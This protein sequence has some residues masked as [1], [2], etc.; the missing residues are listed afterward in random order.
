MKLT[1]NFSTWEFDSPD[2]PFSGINMRIEFIF[3]LQEARRIANIPFLITSG[4]RT[5]EHNEKV[6]GVKNSAHMVGKAADIA[7]HT[8]IN[9]FRI[10]AALLEV[11]FTRIGIYATYIHVDDDESK[12]S[13]VI[14]LA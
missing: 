1:E 10:V 14:F 8:S 13:E 9:R 3:K 2:R 12:S 7:C 6:E 4:Y 11:K 5:K